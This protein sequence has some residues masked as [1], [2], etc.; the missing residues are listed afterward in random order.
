MSD[1]KYQFLRI[2]EMMIYLDFM[3][4]SH[5]YGL[6]SHDS[7]RDVLITYQLL[8]E[9]HKWSHR[10][11]EI[12]DPIRTDLAQV[13]EL[14]FV[15]GKGEPE[16]EQTFLPELRQTVK[17][18]EVVRILHAN[19]LNP[20]G[21][22]S[23]FT[24]QHG[25]INQSTEIP[26]NLTGSYITYYRNGRIRSKYYAID[27][28]KTHEFGYRD[29]CFNPLHYAW[30]FEA[31]LIREYV[32]NLNENPIA[33]YIIVNGQIR[34]QSIYHPGDKPQSIYLL[35]ASDNSI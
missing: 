19:Y 21:H 5:V 27:G 3:T 7:G 23:L 10:I 26:P 20:S 22:L 25:A 30:T 35:H 15:W 17:V 14:K 33:Q 6:G 16:P 31:N 2:C 29:T 32:Y 13:T 11:H 34:T 12:Y 8:P 1:K 28:Q 9:S 4:Q 24:T 18:G